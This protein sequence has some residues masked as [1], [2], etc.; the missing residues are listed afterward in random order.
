M[1]I[2]DKKDETVKHNYNLMRDVFNRNIM[3]LC[4]GKKTMGVKYSKNTVN[5]AL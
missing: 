5:I 1:F 2:K 4:G 3:K